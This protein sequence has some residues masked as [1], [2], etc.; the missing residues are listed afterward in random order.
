MRKY[1]RINATSPAVI[2]VAIEV[3]AIDVVGHSP[4]LFEFA[5]TTEKRRSAKAMEGGDDARCTHLFEL[6]E[7]TEKPGATTSGL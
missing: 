5:E 6:A 7:T 3:P 4:A 1:W 2:G